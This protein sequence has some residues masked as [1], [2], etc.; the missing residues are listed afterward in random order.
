[1]R[2]LAAMY[3]H[4]Q[5]SPVKIMGVV[6]TILLI[7]CSHSNGKPQPE[8]NSTTPG[9]FKVAIILPGPINDQS[10]NQ[11]G[12]EG[13]KLIKKQLGAEIAYTTNVSKNNAE[14]VL[15]QYAQ[16]KFDFIII[17]GGNFLNLCEIVA[18]EFP[19]IKF[20]IVGSYGGNNRNLGALAFRSNEVGYLA[21]VIAALKTKTNKIA[22]IGGEPLLI[23]QE[24]A[25]LLERA[26]KKT[27]PNITVSINWVNSWRDPETAKSLAKAQIANGVDV[28]VTDADFGNIGVVQAASTN[29]SVGVITWMYAIEGIEEKY[30]LAGNNIVARVV[31]QVPQLLLEGAT[32]AQQGRWE[33]K[34]YKFGILEES[35]DLTS[36]NSSLT[37]EQTELVKSIKQEIIA[38]KIDIFP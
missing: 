25:I 9:A 26:A 35:Q 21:G 19:R 37:P 13:L 4:I 33:G 24:Q 18:K 36:F 7:A 20:A 31:Q 1:M 11:S 17:H 5:L 14:K 3:V 22:F 6:L 34:Q 27:R 30:Q 28:L 32:L 12:Y 15:R 16:K 38:G 23:T 2:S 8:F 10:W 29:N